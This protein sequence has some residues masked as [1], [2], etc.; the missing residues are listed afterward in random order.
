MLGASSSIIESPAITRFVRMQ[1]GADT[2]S[3]AETLLADVY[4]ILGG[5]PEWLWL[6]N[7][8]PSG[9]ITLRIVNTLQITS[10]Q[11]EVC[12]LTPGEA[13]LLK[14]GRDTDAEGD[15]SGYA[16]FQIVG[17]GATL[18]DVIVTAA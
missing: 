11:L 17:S 12:R 5:T 15:E 4:P 13:V 1:G 7:I 2:S 3:N 9:A 10:E 18:Y 8:D 16:N 14:I 6:K